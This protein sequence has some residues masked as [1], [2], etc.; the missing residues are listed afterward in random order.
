VSKMSIINPPQIMGKSPRILKIFEKIRKIASKD[1]PVLISGENGT[2]KE[3]IARIIHD[4]SPRQGGPFIAINL[5]SVPRELTEAELFGSETKAAEGR[6]QRFGKIAEATGGTLF[7]EE[8]STMD[9]N[10]KDKMLPLIRDKGIRLNDHDVIQSDVRIIGTTCRNLSELVKKGQY[11]NDLFQAF[12]GL[13]LRI[14]SLRERKED[15]LPLVQYFLNESA[16]KFETGLKELSKDAKDYLTKYD[17]PGNVR[18]LE[19]MIKRA[20]ILSHGSLIEKKDLLMAD[21]GSCSIKEFLEEKLKRYLKE[22]MK[23]ETCNLY[24]T[25]LSEVERS[26]IAIVLQETK[27]N[28]L[29]AAKTLG[30]NRNT[31]RSKI[32]GYKLRI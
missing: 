27:G 22:M 24:E 8:I 2:Y 9:I 14:P 13:H 16:R 6:D 23:L 18:E 5:A 1:T 7:I 3:L 17:W 15:I 4:N 30:I 28:Q 26:L 21:I 29:K 19:S 25:V 12:H 32:K 31:L 11:L 10:I 20:S